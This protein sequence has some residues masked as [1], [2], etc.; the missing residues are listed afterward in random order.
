MG[1][2]HER[3]QSP[4]GYEA[5][6]A[7]CPPHMSW[8]KCVLLQPC[9]CT[10]A[11]NPEQTRAVHGVGFP[12]SCIAQ[13]LRKRGEKE[14]P[15]G[16]RRTRNSCTVWTKVL[17]SSN[18]QPD[19][20]GTSLLLVPESCFTPAFPET[21][22]QQHRGSCRAQPHEPVRGTEQ[23]GGQQGWGQAAGGLPAAARTRRKALCR[24]EAAAPSK[25]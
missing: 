15:L 4:K 12:T 7:F 18:H 3:K 10:G 16:M 14:L 22:Q 9:F 17:S 23:H 5:V 2:E 6:S 1:E 24:Q 19:V 25:E 21:S 11:G 13:L 8:W 20:F